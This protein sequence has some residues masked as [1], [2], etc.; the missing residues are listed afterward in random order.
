MMDHAGRM[1]DPTP[2]VAD[3]RSD[4]PL[5]SEQRHLRVV[6]YSTDATIGGSKLGDAS[7]SERAADIFQRHELDGCAERVTDRTTQQTASN[8]GD[9]VELR[10]HRRFFRERQVSDAQITRR[11]TSCRLGSF[12]QRLAS[13]QTVNA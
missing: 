4:E 7:G 10:L 3:L 6:R 11:A 2:V 5:G 12:A 13:E 8:P 9:F 1:A